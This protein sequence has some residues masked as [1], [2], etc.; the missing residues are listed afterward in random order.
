[1]EEIISTSAMRKM[2]HSKKFGW[3]HTASDGRTEIQI[4]VNLFP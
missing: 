1:M 4:L 3:N 2:K